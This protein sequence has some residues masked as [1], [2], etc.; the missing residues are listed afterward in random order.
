MV[1]LD[2]GRQLY[3]LTYCWEFHTLS[4]GISPKVNA[5]ARLEFEPGYF[6]AA[7]KPWHHGD[8][9]LTFVLLFLFVYLF[10]Y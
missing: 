2:Y 9:C 10:I 4:K 5:I 6:K 3:Y 8:S 7:V 1:A